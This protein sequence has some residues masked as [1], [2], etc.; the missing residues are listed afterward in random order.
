[1]IQVDSDR[2]LDEN[3]GSL[4]EAEADNSED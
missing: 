4:E 2:T 3:N 1:L